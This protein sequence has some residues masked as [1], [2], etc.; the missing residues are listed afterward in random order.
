MVLGV[1]V[2]PTKAEAGRFTVW[3]V[4]PLRYP[5]D[6]CIL[7]WLRVFLQGRYESLNEM[8][9]TRFMKTVG[10]IIG[11]YY[12][13]LLRI[14]DRHGIAL[15][16]DIENPSLKVF[17]EK[18]LCDFLKYQIPMVVKACKGHDGAH[19][20]LVQKSIAGSNMSRF[21]IKYSGETLQPEQKQR[22]QDAGLEVR[23]R[24]GYDTIIS[25]K[26]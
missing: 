1:G 3:C 25:I 2:E 9:Y 22:L 11:D 21:S 17:Q 5:S 4:W 8:L 10:V 20:A 24:F 13:K 15:N 19:I 14:C 23:A 7:S 6:V 26:L 12:Q 18:A 16:L